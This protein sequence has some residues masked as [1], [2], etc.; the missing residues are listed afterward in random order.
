MRRLFA[1]LIA[2]AIIASMALAGPGIASASPSHRITPLNAGSMARTYMNRAMI[3]YTHMSPTAIAGARADGCSYRSIAA[4]AGVDATSCAAHG[5]ALGHE[6]QHGDVDGLAGG[7]GGE[8]DD[9]A[10]V[11]LADGAD[12]GDAADLHQRPVGIESGWVVVVS[13]DGDHFGTRLT[14]RQQGPHDQLLRG[15][16]RRGGVVQVAGDQHRVE[17]FAAGHGD[18]LGEHFALLVQPA[19]ALEGLADVPIGGVQELHGGFLGR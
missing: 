14:K 1:P 12:Q 4:S 3:D 17:R 13:G 11:R 7:P 10:V 15:G 2:A 5:V 19:A 8:A 6:R 9:T 16:G 18:D